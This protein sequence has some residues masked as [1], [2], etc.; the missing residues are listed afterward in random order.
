MAKRSAPPPDD[1]PELDKL[2][3]FLQAKL[4]EANLEEGSR[5]N[6]DDVSTSLEATP[7]PFQMALIRLFVLWKDKSGNY[8]LR[9]RADYR[10]L[11]A[12][13][14][15]RQIKY[16]LRERLLAPEE[17]DNDMPSVSMLRTLFHPLW[18]VWR[19]ERDI[20]DALVGF[21]KSALETPTENGKL[22]GPSAQCFELQLR[23]LAQVSSILDEDSVRACWPRK[24]EERALLLHLLA[25]SSEES[26]TRVRPGRGERQL[27]FS[28]WVSQHFGRPPRGGSVAEQVSS[29]QDIAL[30]RYRAGDARAQPVVAE[31]ADRFLDAQAEHF[32]AS[33]ATSLSNLAVIID[34]HDGAEVQCDRLFK[35]AL[36]LGG[37]ARNSRILFYYAEFL[38]DVLVDDARRQRLVAAAYGGDEARLVGNARSLL[39]EA[40][41]ETLEPKDRLYRDILQARLDALGQTDRNALLKEA[42]GLAVRNA[43]VLLD[44]GRE[45][46][47]RFND[48]LDAT[49]G[50]GGGVLRL[51]EPLQGAIW[52]AQVGAGRPSWPM[53][54]QIANDLV[55]ESAANSQEEKTGLRMNAALVQDAALLAAGERER[56]SALWSQSGALFARQFGAA[57]ASRAALAFLASLVYG[58]TRQ[59]VERMENAG[60]RLGKG[61]LG[62]TPEAWRPLLSARYAKLLTALEQAPN[63]PEKA[64]AAAAAVFGEE[65]PPLACP[66]ELADALGW[67]KERFA[68]ADGG[69]FADAVATLLAAAKGKSA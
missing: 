43:G 55:G 42:W 2:L 49:V 29:F 46:A 12:C 54:V 28:A 3:E 23:A 16:Y 31:Y 10:G 19:D 40:T 1:Q 52:A 11:F 57:G 47:S 56:M 51:K 45:S 41:D 44:G 22:G 48:L 38:L 25:V 58:G 26:G 53:A 8:A 24:S 68:W 21:A 4:A 36:R 18:K 64:A 27:D 50:K 32:G 37:P 35:A 62:A 61:N 65:F 17:G 63:Q 7:K 67:S 39:R 59:T 6:V 13:L 30:T 34:D 5:G 14:T 66:D 33:T 15:P 69:R 20:F 60:P 9:L